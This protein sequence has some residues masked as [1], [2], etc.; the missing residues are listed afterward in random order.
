MTRQHVARR[1]DDD[2]D[3]VALPARIDHTVLGP[4]TTPGDVDRVVDEAIRH[5]TNVCVPPCYVDRART[6]VDAADAIGDANREPLVASVVGFPHGQH[7]TA[8]KVREAEVTARNGADEL[9]V[10]IAVGRLLEAEDDAVRTDLAA[11]TGAVSVPVKAIVAAPLLDHEQ[12]ARA[13]EIAAT[14]DC[15]HAKT[16]TGFNGGGA[17]VAAVET[18]AEYLPVKAS[19]G[20]GSWNRARELL[21]AGATR[22]GASSGDT[23]VREW[24]AATGRDC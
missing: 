23:I 9:D 17:T 11:V 6:R 24:R 13:S 14:A 19:G 22:I 5:G 8:V 12:L 7:A 18:M 21:A 1:M 3:G 4:E 20:I 2:P 15:S 16:A 10:V